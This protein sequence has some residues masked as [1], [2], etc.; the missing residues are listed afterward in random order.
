[1]EPATRSAN[2]LG[3]ASALISIAALTV[4]LIA[5]TCVVSIQ[6][7]RS[8]TSERIAAGKYQ[9]GDLRPLTDRIDVAV[10]GLEMAVFYLVGLLVGGTYSARLQCPPTASPNPHERPVGGADCRPG[11]PGRCRR[12]S[13]GSWP[14]RRP[15]VR[16][17]ARAGTLVP[18]TMQLQ[19]RCAASIAAM[20]IF[21]IC[22]IASN[23]RSC[24]FSMEV[25]RPTRESTT[26]S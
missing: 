2:P 18:Q 23:A 19:P 12:G 20:S 15:G 7:R 14:T 9:G 3:M 5:V 6:S 25:S 13:G 4:C 16:R 17:G 24:Q 10:T 21:T 11:R 26:G 8:E 22:I 1:M